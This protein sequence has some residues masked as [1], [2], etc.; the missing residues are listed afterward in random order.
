MVRDPEEIIFD[1][2]RGKTDA[3]R[4]KSAVDHC[5][6]FFESYVKRSVKPYPT[7]G[8]EEYEWKRSVE[9]VRAVLS[10]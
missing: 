7:L 9:S 5:K 1:L 8:P 3:A 6:A 4:K 10:L 2:C